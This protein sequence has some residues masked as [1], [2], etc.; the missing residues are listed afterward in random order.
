[1][2]VEKGLLSGNLK[3]VVW[4]EKKSKAAGWLSWTKKGKGER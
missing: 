2:A 3:E 1:V 4:N